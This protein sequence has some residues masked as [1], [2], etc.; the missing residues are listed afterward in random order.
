MMGGLR[1]M[2]GPKGA[3]SWGRG[4]VGMGQLGDGK[5]G[6]RREGS[7]VSYPGPE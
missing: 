4:G 3:R 1:G 5:G 2:E 7:R 6:E